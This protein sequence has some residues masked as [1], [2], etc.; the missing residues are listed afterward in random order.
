MKNSKVKAS[1]LVLSLLLVW[2]STS[3]AQQFVNVP[4]AQLWAGGYTDNGIGTARVLTEQ[5]NRFTNLTEVGQCERT[6]AFVIVAGVLPTSNQT[7]YFEQQYAQLLASQHAN[8][9]VS[10]FISGCTS[11]GRW[12]RALRV[13]TFDG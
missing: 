7:M 13:T 5:N 1:C 12:P 11:D 9:N 3:S 4:V 10:V 8:K 6:D 2:C